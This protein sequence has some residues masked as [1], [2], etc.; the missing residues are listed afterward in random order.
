MVRNLLEYS[1]VR[2]ANISGTALGVT[3]WNVVR[4]GG[5][6]SESEHRTLGGGQ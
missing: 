2:N 1:S 3:L 5:H 6:V 4:D